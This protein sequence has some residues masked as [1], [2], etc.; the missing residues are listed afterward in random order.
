MDQWLKLWLGGG[1]AEVEM[2]STSS[3]VAGPSVAPLTDGH[4]VILPRWREADY[5]AFPAAETPGGAPAAKPSDGFLPGS[6]ASLVKNQ[7]EKLGAA[8][9][10]GTDNGVVVLEHGYAPTRR[11]M[12]GSALASMPV[13]LNIVPVANVAKFWTAMQGVSLFNALMDATHERYPD[14]KA[15]MSDIAFRSRRDT[16]VEDEQEFVTV[17]MLKA[18]GN[19]FSTDGKPAAVVLAVDEER[20]P[21]FPRD[22][23]RYLIHAALQRCGGSKL[24]EWFIEPAVSEDAVGESRPAPTYAG[25]GTNRALTLAGLIAR[26]LNAP[27]NAPT[28][29]ATQRIE[30]K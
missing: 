19:V 16:L 17:V 2:D 29:A 15:D 6:V 22:G 12:F 28:N 7:V 3:F 26:I 9:S 5:R 18:D 20:V 14:F 8:S 11:Y 10:K 24:R 1:T 21:A 13:M 23:G 4:R 27:A 25:L 30:E